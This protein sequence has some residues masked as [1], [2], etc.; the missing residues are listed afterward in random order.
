MQ[1][2]RQLLTFVGVFLGLFLRPEVIAGFVIP[3]IARMMPV[4]YANYI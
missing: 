1:L 3:S 2:F 4:S